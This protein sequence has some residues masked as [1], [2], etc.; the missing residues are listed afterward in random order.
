MR[1]LH[2]VHTIAVT[3]M[4]L[5]PT[6]QSARIAIVGGGASGMFAAIHC[7]GLDTVVLE[8][9]KQLLQKVKISGGGRCNVLHDVSKSPNELLSGYPRGSRELRGILTKHF[10][11]QAA[12]A[13]FQDH[14]VELK[15]EADGRMFPTTDSSQTVIDALLGAAKDNQVNIQ[16]QARVESVECLVPSGFRIQYRQKQQDDKSV[17]RTLESDAVILASGS[18]RAGYALLQNGLLDDDAM[19]E[20]VP[21]L[22][23]LRTSSDVLDG[24]AGISVPNVAISFHPVEGE[25]AKPNRRLRNKQDLMQHGPLLITHDR[26]LSGPA[27][28]RLSAFAAREMAATRYRGKLQVH[29][30]GDGSNENSVFDQLWSMTI[31]HPQR[32][33]GHSCP[34]D[35]NSIP[36]RLWWALVERISHVDRTKR[37]SE[38]SK[39][40]A[41]ALA[42]ALVS[43]PLEMVGKGTFKEEFVTAGGISLSAIDMKTMQCK[44]IP[45]LFV[46]GELIN[47]DGITGGYNFMNCW[48]TGFVAGTSAKAYVESLREKGSL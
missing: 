12:A 45:G 48:G 9:S 18:A 10:P 23:T 26:G 28:L 16:K 24:L 14:N 32:T 40:Q 7:R 19:V 6:A 47:V 22:F 31:R 25:H 17:S 29:W 36:K 34:I 20:T 1:L 33:V 8:A 35:G 4:T 42:I 41:R 15:T 39:K 30:L 2:L 13:W 21:S 46:C 27:A 11:A 3:V 5:I 43:C 37:W 38:V 44:N